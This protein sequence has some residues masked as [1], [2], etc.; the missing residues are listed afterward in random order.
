MYHHDVDHW[1]TL[2]GIMACTG[3][4]TAEV[5]LYTVLEIFD[6]AGKRFA[7]DGDTKT[8][9]GEPVEHATQ[10]EMSSQFKSGTYDVQV[11]ACTYYQGTDEPPPAG[12]DCEVA[13]QRV[14][15]T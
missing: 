2:K 6:E 15:I 4:T 13:T 14:T 3:G 5:D 7:S 1:L 11:T 12:G 8:C 10:F 9:T